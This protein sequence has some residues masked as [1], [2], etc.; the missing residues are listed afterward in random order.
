LKLPFDK[1]F[2]V[3]EETCFGDPY[4]VSA[5]INR[6][7]GETFFVSD[8]DV[9]VSEDNPEDL[10]ENDLYFLLPDPSELT[11]GR[12]LAFKFASAEVREHAD[13]IYKIFQ[14]GGAFSRFKNLLAHIGKLDDWYAF[15]QK[16]QRVELLEWCE[17]NEI[18]VEK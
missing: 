13:E 14:R 2:S 16:T 12:D 9:D 10:F 17:I 18:E 1:I 15:Q 4:S 6:E 11:S 5:Y 7:N 8:F 3:F